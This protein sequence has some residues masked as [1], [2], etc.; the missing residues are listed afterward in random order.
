METPSTML[1]EPKD[2]DFVRVR[3]YIPGILEELKYAQ[4]DNF[5]GAVIY[6]FQDVYLRYGTVKKLM[7]VQAELQQMGLGLKIWDG[8]R[9]VSA[10]FKLWEIYPDDTYVANPNLGYSNHSRGFAVDLTLVDLNGAELEMPTAFDDFSGKADRDYSEIPEVPRNNALLLQNI[11]EKHGFQ[12]YYGEWWHFN[13][14]VRYEVEH[15]FDPGLISLWKVIGE[16]SVPLLTG[17]D[18]ASQVIGSLEPGQIVTVMGYEGDYALINHQGQ[19][20]FVLCISLF[21][22]S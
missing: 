3:D 15:V 12:G 20:G 6:N 9:P 5:T 10:Q 16:S 8:F 13:D 2:S 14:T 7:A 21:P 19:R 17:S 22:A 18:P 11:M 4:A 1:T